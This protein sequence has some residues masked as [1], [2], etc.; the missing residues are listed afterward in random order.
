[1]IAL[2]FLAVNG[3]LIKYAQEVR[4]YAP[5]LCLSVFSV[6]LFARFYF[7]GKNIWIL[8][9]VN[10]LLVY[11]HY[12][13]WFVIAAQ[14]AAIFAFQRVKIRHVLIM[15]GIAL[16]AFVPWMIAVASASAEGADVRQ[17]IG[18]MPRPGLRA[19]FDFAFDAIEPFYYQQSS[20]DPSTL[21]YISIPLLMIVAAAAVLMFLK[22]KRDDD[23]DTVNLMALFV[24]I[25]VAIAFVTSWLAPVS[26]WGSR[27][28]IIVFAPISIM[29]AIAFCSVGRDVYRYALITFAGAF[30][31]IG[32]YVQAQRPHVEYVWCSWERIAEQ[33]VR[34]APV[35]PEAKQLYAFEDLAAYHLWFAVRET[36]GYRVDLVRVEGLPNDPAYCLPRGFD[37]IGTISLEKIDGDLFWL[38]LRNPS[39]KAQLAQDT[40]ERLGPPIGALEDRGFEIEEVGSIPAGRETLHLIK[41]RR[42]AST[43]P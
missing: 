40:R 14:V 6:W 38:A 33:W 9:L 20:A 1:M 36:D 27:H 11:T 5:L 32:F 24:A 15:G 39:S 26:I 17:N 28:L 4:M 25:P 21:L 35:S 41:V 31:A 30:I 18:W 16:A 23:R 42:I 29:T 13:G 2:T 37:A 19:V 3:S 7:R 10:I 8:T 12:F 34:S 22:W 43:T